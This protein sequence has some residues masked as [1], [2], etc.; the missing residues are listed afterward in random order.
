MIAKR[1]LAV[2]LTTRQSAILQFM[3]RHLVECQRLPTL[4]EIAAEFGMRSANGVHG[5]IRALARH[6]VVVRLDKQQAVNYRLQG[7]RIRLEETPMFS[8][9]ATTMHV[10]KNCRVATLRHQRK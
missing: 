3:K 2:Q 6:G 1:N 4:R 9:R 7:V 5:H 10:R 8:P